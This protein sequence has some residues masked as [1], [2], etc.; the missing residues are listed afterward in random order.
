M[1]SNGGPQGYFSLIQKLKEMQ[2]EMSKKVTEI[3]QNISQN[4]MTGIDGTKIPLT[5]EEIE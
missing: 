4:Q 2:F 5:A 3:K 1:Q